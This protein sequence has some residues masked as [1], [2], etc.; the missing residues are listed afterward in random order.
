MRLVTIVIAM[1]ALLG[2][3]A[4]PRVAR[5]GRLADRDVVDG[6]RIEDL[7]ADRATTTVRFEEGR[8]SG[9]TGCNQYTGFLQAG[10]SALRVSETRSTRM[11]CAPPVMQQETR[12]LSALAAVRTARREGDR[13]S[14]CSTRPATCACGSLPPP[15]RWARHGGAR[16]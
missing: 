7:V 12:F 9:R 15:R 4:R 3:C 8:V 1:L 2:G 11:A 6:E 16:V 14:C 10:G 13:V 5:P